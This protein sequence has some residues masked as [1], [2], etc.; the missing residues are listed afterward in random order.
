M[1]FKDAPQPS[2][3]LM[4]GMYALHEEVMCRRRAAGTMPWNWNAGLASPPM[5]P[6]AA[7][8]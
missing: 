5:P 3:G 4:P 8:C 1:A 6:K 2:A 7:G